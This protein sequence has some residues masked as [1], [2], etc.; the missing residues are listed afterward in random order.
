VADDGK[1]DAT[2]LVAI[3]IPTWRRP[4]VADALVETISEND[5]EMLELYLDG[6]EPSRSS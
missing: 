1:G 4:R 2:T 5:E 3:P 6:T